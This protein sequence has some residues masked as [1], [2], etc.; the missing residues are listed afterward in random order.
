MDIRRILRGN[1]G[2]SNSHVQRTLDTE[3]S[4]STNSATTASFTNH[5]CDLTAQKLAT[6]LCIQV[7]LETALLKTQTKDN[8]SV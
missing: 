4:E 6:I 2:D 5:L 1:R 3:P 8:A 7:K